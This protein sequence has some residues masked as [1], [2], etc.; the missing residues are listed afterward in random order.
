MTQYAV[1]TADPQFLDLSRFITLHSLH[2]E[3]HLNRTRV[4]ISDPRVE[5]LFL[6]QFTSAF[7]VLESES[8]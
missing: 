8:I 6:A 1:L 3:P 5:L 4:W 7:R 2:Y